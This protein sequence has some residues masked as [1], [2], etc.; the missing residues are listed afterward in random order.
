MASSRV[1]PTKIIPILIQETNRYQS[2]LE[3][4]FV[5]QQGGETGTITT[6]LVG[7]STSSHA[8][9]AKPGTITTTLT[10]VS[11]SGHMNDHVSYAVTTLTKVSTSAHANDHGA[12]AV[13][14]LVGISQ[15]AVATARHI[16]HIMTVLGGITIHGVI[17]DPERIAGRTTLKGVSQIAHTVVAKVGFHGA[18]VLRGI[19]QR[20]RAKV[21]TGIT[22]TVAHT[23]I[24]KVTTSL[25]Q[26]QHE[27][28]TAVTAL[29]GVIQQAIIY[30]APPV[31]PGGARQFW[32]WG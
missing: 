14:T 12:H 11:T 30:D 1:L 25:Y 22:I 27:T 3:T 21:S 4:V 18:T 20:A 26:P 15:H 7:V 28:S 19:S 8:F 32:T 24:F 10:K 5:N 2:I 23:R 31:G 17:K 6:T 16:A 13:T 9:D 29:H